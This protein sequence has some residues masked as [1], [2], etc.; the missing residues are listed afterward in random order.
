MICLQFFQTF[1]F[2]KISTTNSISFIYFSFISLI[3][4]YSGG[5]KKL[6][7]RRKRHFHQGGA[8]RKPLLSKKEPKAKAPKAK[9]AVIKGVHSRKKKTHMSPTFHQIRLGSSQGSPSFKKP[10][11]ENHNSKGVMY[12]NVHCSSIY[13][14]QVMEAT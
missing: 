3:Y 8:E 1:R 12:Q 2:S 14:S 13:N 11:R 4:L 9:K 6:F 7:L 10:L 5:E